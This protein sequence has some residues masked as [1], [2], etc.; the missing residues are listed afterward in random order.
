MQAKKPYDKDTLLRVVK[1][2]AVATSEIIQR[3][4][5]RGVGFQLTSAVEAEFRA[6]GARPELIEAMRANYRA[7]AQPPASTTA[8]RPASSSTPANS[9]P[10]GP[11]LSKSEIL[12]L[13][14]G[15]VPSDRIEQY[16]EVRGV[17]FAATPETVAE[18][19]AAG[20]SRSLLGVISEKAMTNSSAASSTRPASMS[21][22][23]SG[24]DYDDLTGQATAAI[25]ASDTQGAIELLQ[26]AIRLDT[27]Q[28][29]A[30]AL[31]GFVQL[32]GNHDIQAA[33]RAMRAAIERN[34]GAAFRVYHDHDGFFQQWCQGSFFVTK[35]GMTF[36]A[37]DGNHTFEALDANVKE[38]K[39]N[40][41]VGAQVGAFHVKVNQGGKDKNYN[42]APATTNKAESNLI[43]RLIQG[44]Q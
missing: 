39:L 7:A 38:A 5:Q 2:N 24:P 17:N 36:K 19:K 26:D 23:N 30:Y 25:Q 3:V 4:E 6:A 10:A 20:G 22:R 27:S 31:L 1:L 41:I 13:L 14:Q 18:I 42:F 12:T 40:S 15:G 28:P 44:Y 16:V 32:Y 37:D 9:V 29:T 8:S 33:E 21:D 35:S 11:P 34:G 43:I